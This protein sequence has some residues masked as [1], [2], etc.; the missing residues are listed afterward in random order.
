MLQAKKIEKPD[1]LSFPFYG[2]SIKKKQKKKNYYLKLNHINKV[3]KNICK[4]N[5]NKI[6]EFVLPQITIQRVQPREQKFPSKNVQKKLK[7]PGFSTIPE[8]EKQN[9]QKNKCML[10]KINGELKELNNLD[11]CKI[12]KNYIPYTKTSK[13][14]IFNDSPQKHVSYKYYDLNNFEIIPTIYQTQNCNT[15]LIKK[16]RQASKNTM[17]DIR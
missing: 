12:L 1:L 5:K 15:D 14:N 7:T 2:Y 8:E 9:V 17:T 11:T 10:K 4:I 16:C 13:F 6:D 3:M